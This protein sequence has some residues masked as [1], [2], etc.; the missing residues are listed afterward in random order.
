MG[1][2]KGMRLVLLG[3]PGSGKGTQAELLAEHLVVPA[4]ST[5]EMVRAAI[6]SGSELGRQVEQ[7][8]ASGSLVDDATMGSIVRQRLGESDARDGFLLD[9]YPR[10]VPQAETLETILGELAVDLNGVLMIDVPEDELVRRLLDRGR[11]DDQEDVIRHRLDVYREQTAPLVALYR[12]RG[13][14]LEIDGLQSIS[15][16]ADSIVDAL[17]GIAEGVEA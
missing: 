12:E 7:I 5:G 11:S 8:V 16:V 10:T 3:P 4:I 2:V 17:S 1:S 14:L 6:A 9:G 15:Q 13:K